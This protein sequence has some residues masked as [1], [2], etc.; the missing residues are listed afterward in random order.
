MP[1]TVKH[2]GNLTSGAHTARGVL[3]E[4]ALAGPGYDYFWHFSSRFLERSG[5]E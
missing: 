3:V 2:G 4:F 1:R 5:T